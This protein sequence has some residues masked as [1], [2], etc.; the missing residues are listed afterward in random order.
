[1]RKRRDPTKVRGMSTL[2]DVA[3][4]FLT[5]EPRPGAAGLCLRSRPGPTFTMPPKGR[6]ARLE[7]YD[8]LA[9]PVAND[10]RPKKRYYAD[11][12]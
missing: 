8:P 12:R 6:T 11:S 9:G 2:R 10:F 4:E 5:M 1:M 7:E 3:E